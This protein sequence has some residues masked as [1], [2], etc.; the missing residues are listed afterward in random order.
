M[1][2]YANEVDHYRA[3]DITRIKVENTIFCFVVAAL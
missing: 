3:D 1:Y 2:P